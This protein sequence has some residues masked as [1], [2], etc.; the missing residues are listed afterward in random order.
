M[1][2]IIRYMNRDPSNTAGGDGTTPGIAGSTRAFA[3]LNEA[4]T[5]MFASNSDLSAPDTLKI[6]CLGGSA[7]TTQCNFSNYQFNTGAAGRVQIIADSAYRHA[8]IF[9]TSKYYFSGIGNVAFIVNVNCRVEINGVQ[10]RTT[11]TSPV[12]VQLHGT[13]TAGEAHVYNCLFEATTANDATGSA[14]VYSSGSHSRKIYAV[15]N[16]CYGKWNAFC[17]ASF[18][19]TGSKFIAYHNTVI[20]TTK[21]GLSSSSSGSGKVF[22]KNNRIA[23]PTGTSPACYNFGSTTVTSAG[24]YS[25]DA[26]SPDG[27]SFQG[28]TF[29]WADAGS[30]NYLITSG[31]T[32]TGADLS[33]DSELPVTDDILGNARTSFYAG[34]HEFTAA[35]PTYYD[36]EA[37]IFGSLPTVPGGGGASGIGRG[38]IR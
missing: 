25:E 10:F 28:K 1:S 32:F 16:I 20:G 26:T 2:T 27:A 21:Y 14:A 29:T 24:N 12:A 34:A 17:S 6:I 35:G 18:L 15:N 22:W 36:V 30:N 31:D 4:L 7:E 13:D 9:D 19:A 33:A 23:T 11:G 8:A 3:S 37:T 38:L 5:A